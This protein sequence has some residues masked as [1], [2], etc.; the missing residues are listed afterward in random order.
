MDIIQEDPSE[1]YLAPEVTLD[2]VKSIPQNNQ[3]SH[4]MIQSNLQDAQL[5]IAVP[6][7]PME[8]LEYELESRPRFQ[9][10][11]LSRNVKLMSELLKKQK[12]P[13]NIRGVEIDESQKKKYSNKKNKI[14]QMKIEIDEPQYDGDGQLIIPEQ[15]SED[16]L[17]PHLDGIFMAQ[18]LDEEYQDQQEYFSPTGQMLEGEDL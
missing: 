8:T 11:A 17:A 4:E 16:E 12:T 15:T 13:K 10:V 18:L 1:K 2:S 14:L 9:T 7:P 5:E 3:D 6:E